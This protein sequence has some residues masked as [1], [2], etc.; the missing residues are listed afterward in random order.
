M[1]VWRLGVGD[2]RKAYAERALSPVDVVSS[3][4]ERIE[5]LD[6]PIG[7]FRVVLTA[8]ALKDA[9][10]AT[11]RIASGERGSLLGIPVAVKELFDV[12]GAPSCYG[13]E[14]FAGRV[15][16][17][18]AGAVA[19]LREAG[20]IIVGTTRSHEFGWGITTQHQTLGS[21][22]NPFGL[23][24]TPGGSSGGSAAALA[25]GFVPLALGSDTGGSIRIPASFCGVA[26]LK[27]TYGRVTKRGA[28][29]LA[30]SL[31][32]PGPMTR[33]AA[34]LAV[35]L[36]AFSGYDSAEPSTLLAGPGVLDGWS[37]RGARVGICPDLHLTPLTA[38]YRRAFNV[39]VAHLEGLGAAVTKMGFPEAE[40]IR[41]T[42]AAI[43]MAEA[44][45]IHHRVLGTFP[46]Q[47][48]A[49]GPDVR[50]RLEMAAEVSV[51][52]YLA[53]GE[54]REV[55]T[56]RFDGLFDEIEVLLT[57]VSAGPPSYV[58]DPDMVE[59]D[60]RSMPL[61]DVVMDYTVPQDLFGV[62]A[63]AIRAGTDE[64]GLPIG[65]QLSGRRGEEARVLATATRLEEALSSEFTWPA[66]ALG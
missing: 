35:A 2:L 63:C 44:H 12:A 32:H 22:H 24:R 65:V 50:R 64:D 58:S 26:G 23:D 28:I 62:P 27:P 4:L 16:P 11:E 34:D 5:R 53:A 61:R 39:A 29:A 54:R 18:D 17:V 45:D 43:Q 47:A 40:T 38:E 6:G 48:R 19:K 56:G 51:G 8:G 14:V 21:T 36:E 66:A 31:D 15:A 37:L 55:L 52:D 46:N 20:A 3:L 30:P 10:A 42:F 7:A 57:P 49:Y 33:R 41:P 9:R 25:M 13:S 1:E 60:G 59:H